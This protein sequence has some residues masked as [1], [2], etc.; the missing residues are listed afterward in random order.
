MFD[1]LGIAFII[2]AVA[3]ALMYFNVFPHWSTF[4]FT[5]AISS[6]DVNQEIYPKAASVQESLEVIQAPL[7]EQE[8]ERTLIDES[9]P[10]LPLLNAAGI[11][12]V[13]G[14]MEYMKNNW[15]EDLHMIG[16]KRADEIRRYMLDRPDV[17]DPEKYG[18]ILTDEA[19]PNA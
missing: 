16:P 17:Y 11:Y 7:D 12:Y 6:E 5:F 4:D 19:V 9:M 10:H 8:Q 13:D 1:L 2:L 18:V 14:L 3:A 15:L